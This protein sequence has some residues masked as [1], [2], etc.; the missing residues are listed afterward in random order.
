MNN[1]KDTV[2]GNRGKFVMPLFWGWANPFVKWGSIVLLTSQQF[3]GLPW[4][5]LSKNFYLIE[6]I[7]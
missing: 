3:T 1:L 2:R 6:P 4:Y 5:L 7:F